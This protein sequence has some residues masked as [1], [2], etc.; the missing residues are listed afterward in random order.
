[1]FLKWIKKIID[2]K[3]TV[4]MEENNTKL[5]V[6]GIDVP[7]TYLSEK[8]KEIRLCKFMRILREEDNKKYWESVEPYEI[9]DGN[10]CV[11]SKSD[12]PNETGWI[13]ISKEELKYI[14]SKM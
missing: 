10:L 11:R 1:M 2:Y 13:S 4:L 7:F 12:I 5:D 9:I 6:V 14:L 8:T 3:N